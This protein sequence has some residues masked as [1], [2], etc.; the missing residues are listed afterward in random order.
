[1]AGQYETFLDVQGESAVL[2]A[3]RQC[4]ASL[5]APR[6]LAYLGE[7]EIDP[8]CVAMAV[9][10]ERLVPADVAGVLF[11][12]NPHDGGQREMLVEAAVGL[13]ESVVSGQVQP[14][15]LR[16]DRETG[17][18]LAAAIADR[19]GHPGANGDC[20]ETARPQR[21]CLD[22]RDVH[23]LWQ[24]GRR[25]V[26]HFGSP[27][28]IEWAIHGG[29]LYV[30]QSRPITTLDCVEA[31]EDVL[32]AARR[33]L[34]Q[35]SAAGRGPWVLHNL[36]ES[37]S[38]PTPLTWSVIS[39][40]MSGAGGLGAMYRQA[41]F[42]PSATADREGFLERIAGRVYMDAS[43]APEMF[44]EDFPFAYAMEDLE[45]SPD[46]SQTP[47]TVPRGSL[48]SRW[49]ARRR[50]AAVESRLHA[51]SLDTQRQLREAIFP[52]FA[53]Y[54]AD[55]KRVDLTR[56]STDGLV[57]CWQE[58][59]KQVLDTFAS[60][61]LLPSLI[62]AM[63]IAELRV[64][65][66]ENFWDEDPEVLAYLISSGGPPDRT[67]TR[68][69]E[70]YEVGQGS[71][72]WKRGLLSTATAPPTNWNWPPRGGASRRRPGP[73]ARWQPALPPARAPWSAIAAT[74]TRSIAASQRF[75]SDSPAAIAGSSIT[76][77]IWS[78][79]T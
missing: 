27:Q 62:G 4:W 1:M 6:A 30:L 48:S 41:G 70:L 59:E 47:P 50:L 8:S 46:A 9:V 19:K 40:F 28:D 13:G 44:F 63:A 22:G 78:G 33:R 79:D 54:V 3:V 32:Q 7:H 75:V 12:T 20:H 10:V 34:Y 65:L 36:A 5:Y 16:V 61:S 52:A 23:R 35:E 14:D 56:L 17:W 72:R 76:A 21:S 24:L 39:R 26:D 15:T 37:L 67:V 71:A 69:A 29:K 42:E 31:R 25:A 60:Q 38:H 43:R 57:E 74:R 64:L 51:L 53:R 68:D 58:R 66:A 49:K 73:C 55:A 45:R 77:S 11:T 2:D 18:V